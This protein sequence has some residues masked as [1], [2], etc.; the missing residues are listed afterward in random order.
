MFNFF[1]LISI[2]RFK[3]VSYANKTITLCTFVVGY[4]H[5]ILTISVL[6]SHNM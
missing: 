3:Y 2:Y 1:V 4:I 5:Q 6:N